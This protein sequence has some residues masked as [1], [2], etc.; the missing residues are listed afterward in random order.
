MLI[1]LLLLGWAED[2]IATGQYKDYVY[3][4]YSPRTLWYHDHAVRKYS[5]SSLLGF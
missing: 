4:N 3:P 2:T 1:G 5:F